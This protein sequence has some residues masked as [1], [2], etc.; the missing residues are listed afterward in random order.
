MSCSEKILYRSVQLYGDN[1][2]FWDS[3]RY[4]KSASLCVLRWPLN[5]G[6]DQ[7][8]GDVP[9]SGLRCVPSDQT[10]YLRTWT[11]LGR[12]ETPIVHEMG[13]YCKSHRTTWLS[14]VI[15]IY[16]NYIKTGSAFLQ[17]TIENQNFDLWTSTFFLQWKFLDVALVTA[18]KDQDKSEQLINP[19]ALPSLIWSTATER[20]GCKTVKLVTGGHIFFKSG[21]SFFSLEVPKSEWF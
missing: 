15:W 19:M 7:M 12:L 13:S 2:G 10:L 6:I 20:H 11:V 1:L 3:L 9:P 4:V 17:P 18:P 14:K 5:I 16:L 8:D 21:T